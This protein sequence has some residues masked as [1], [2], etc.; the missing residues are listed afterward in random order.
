MRTIGILG[1]MGPEAT[2][3]LCQEIFSATPAMKDQNHIPII[4]YSNPIIPDRTEAILYDGA[5]PVAEMVKTA[6]KLEQ[7]GA[8]FILMPC[9]TAH[10]FISEIEKHINVRVIHMIKETI[11][12]V[13]NNYPDTH[14]IGL[15]AT[16]GTIKTGLYSQLFSEYGIEVV[17]PD[18]T[19]QETFVM[20]A[21]YGKKGIKAK[22]KIKPRALL[23]EAAK[24]L[25]AQGVDIIIAGCTEIPI[26][27]KQDNVDFVLLDPSK[28][29]AEVAVRLALTPKIKAV[30]E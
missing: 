7:C 10:Y 25:R 27:L 6:Q 16:S 3:K 30:A 24:R 17:I 8:E 20:S 12:F 1:G 9:N 5:S 15:L 14:R 23:R 18:E 21:I 26:V 22:Y 13:Q 29:M 11:R 2:T 19:T 4:S 28:I